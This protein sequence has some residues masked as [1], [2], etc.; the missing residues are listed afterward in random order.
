MEPDFE[1]RGQFPITLRPYSGTI[2]RG[3]N[4]KLF[5]LG[6]GSEL[7]LLAIFA[8]REAFIEETLNLFP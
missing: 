2:R 5:S 8:D 7:F 6:A 4:L 3:D 1:R